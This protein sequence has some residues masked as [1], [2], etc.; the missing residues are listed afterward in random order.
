VTEQE[1]KNDVNHYW[2]KLGILTAS[3][4]DVSKLV[5]LSFEMQ[6]VICLVGEAGI[7]KTQIFKQVAEDLGYGIMYYYLAHLEREDLGGIP[8]PNDQKTAYRF[9]CE[10]SIHELIHTPKPVVMV[11]DEWNR[12][13]KPV[14]NAAFTLM[15]QRRFGA[16]TLPDHIHIGAA[17]NPSEGAYLVNEAEKDPAFRRRLCFVGVRADPTVWTQWA[18]GRGKVH[19]LVCDYIANKPDHLMDVQA[20]EAGKIYANPAAWEKVSDTLKVMDRLN[21]NLIENSTVLRLKLAGHIGAGMTESFMAWLRESATAIDPIDVLKHYK[22]KGR[23]KVL[24]LVEGNKNDTLSE[25][26]EAV[27]LTM[28]SREMPPAEIAENVGQFAVDLP[29]D[30]SMAFFSKVTKHLQS[31][32]KPEYKMHLSRTLAKFDS[33]RKALSRIQESHQKVEDEKSGKNGDI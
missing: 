29:E 22:S 1:L 6:H 32:G 13:E 33:Y 5:K 23:A 25:V 27:A 2:E 17:M 15:E 28:V 14:M 19:T 18:I 7:G 9:L 24:K 20:R 16:Y 4:N 12:G 8:M 21:L 3:L 10:E 11:L 30:V 26:C 31:L